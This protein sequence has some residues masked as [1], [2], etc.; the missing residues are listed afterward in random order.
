MKDDGTMS[1]PGRALTPEAGGTY[2]DRQ[3]VR[4]PV[5]REQAIFHALPGLLQHAIENAPFFRRH[6]AAIDPD[7]VTDR[8]ALSR[9]PLMRPDAHAGH[10]DG[11][12]AGRAATPVSRL[13]K[14]HRPSERS[15]GPEGA[16]LDYWRLARAMFAAGFRP[17]GLVL[18]SL[19]YHLLP[20][21]SMAEGGARALG[22]P[23]IA[24]GDQDPAL[25]AELVADL[26]PVAYAGSGSFLLEL[27]RTAARD[28]RDATSL[29]TALIV[30]EVLDPVPRQEL[31][32]RFKVAAFHAFTTAELGLVA[33]ETV[34]GL[35]WVVDESVIVELVPPDGGQPVPPGEVGE[36]VVTAFNPDYPLIRLATGHR[37]VEVPGESPCGRTNRRLRLIDG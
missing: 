30:G 22:C 16:R 9:L 37:G 27:L 20:F 24:A 4:N 8:A 19:S 17:G 18:N 1:G 14:I 15:Y 32:E 5:E 11:A 34:A 7:S 10:D 12:F 35:P 25:Q 3:E 29:R 21:G 23:V 6:L 28:G 26:A 36:L 2:Y 33:Y 13:A 31:A